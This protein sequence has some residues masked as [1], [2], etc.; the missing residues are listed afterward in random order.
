[1]QP[2]TNE[3]FNKISKEQNSTVTSRQSGHQNK[4]K[5]LAQL[6]KRPH[7]SGCRKKI[8]V[9]TPPYLKLDQLNIYPV[10]CF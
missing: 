2:K 8:K 1:M 9:G 4:Q 7:E 6:K 5:H 3:S 10:I